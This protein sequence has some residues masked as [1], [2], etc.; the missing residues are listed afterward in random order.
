V[1][2]SAVDLFYRCDLGEECVIKKRDNN[3]EE[4]RIEDEIINFGKDKGLTKELL[5]A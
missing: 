5:V 1:D 2:P 4:D 3:H